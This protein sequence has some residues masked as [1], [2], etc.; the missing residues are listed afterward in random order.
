MKGKEISKNWNC[1]SR[2]VFRTFCSLNVYKNKQPSAKKKH[3]ELPP[4]NLFDLFWNNNG[5]FDGI[6]YD[7]KLCIDRYEISS[8]ELCLL[9]R[10]RLLR[11]YYKPWQED[12]NWQICTGVLIGYIY[13]VADTR[14][15]DYII[16][17]CLL[18]FSEHITL[19]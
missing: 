5:Y 14:M 10:L 3:A 15:F 2:F 17:F 4:C 18:A 13:W 16:T 7:R 12:V 1:T 19:A 6:I 9:R 11:R 8:D